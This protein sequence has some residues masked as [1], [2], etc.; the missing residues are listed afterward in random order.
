MV[1][2]LL[3]TVWLVACTRDAIITPMFSL[4]KRHST[5][6]IR[7][8][9]RYYPHRTKDHAHLNYEIKELFV[10]RRTLFSVV[11]FVIGGMLMGRT[12]WE[13]G[14]ELIGL[15]LTFTIGCVLFLI[16]GMVLH[17]FHESGE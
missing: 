7:L 1:E 3:Y 13:Y 11:G 2:G 16:S 15:P 8:F 10:G 9:A 14:R 6:G 12:L 5:H 4:K 17:S